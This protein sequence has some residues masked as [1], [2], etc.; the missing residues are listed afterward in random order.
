[1]EE[2]LDAGQ[3][4]AALVQEAQLE[5]ARVKI[6]LNRLVSI[7]VSQDIDRDSFVAQKEELLAKKKQLQEGIKKNETTRCRGSN[8]S[9]NG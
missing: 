8:F 4:S 5:M 6:S 3:S 7:Y 9:P 1:L 2:R